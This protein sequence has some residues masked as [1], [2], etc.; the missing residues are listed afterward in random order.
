MN[1]IYKSKFWT[2]CPFVKWS[3]SKNHN[4]FC[5]I[6]GKSFIMKEYQDNSQMKSII[7]KGELGNYKDINS[8]L[9]LEIEMEKYFNGLTKKNNLYLK[10]RNRSHHTN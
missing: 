7:L 9:Q 1:S 3:L 10:G 4:Y 6:C 8:K 5:P 2:K